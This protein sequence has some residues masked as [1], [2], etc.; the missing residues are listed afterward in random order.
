MKTGDKPQ[1]RQGQR[2]LLK[3]QGL[4]TGRATINLRPCN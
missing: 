2:G 1:N 4:Q 3:K